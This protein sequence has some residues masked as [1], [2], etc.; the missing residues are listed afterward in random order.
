MSERREAGTPE[1]LQ[2]LLSRLQSLPGIGR[3]SAERIAFWVLKSSHEEAAAL[4]NAITDVKRAVHHCRICWNL[5]ESD[6]CR[7]CANDQRDASII[8]VVEQPR[9]LLS[10]E[11]A[12]MYRGTYHVLMGR[13]D[14][15][16]GVGPD[17]LT[18][19]DLLRRVADAAQNARGAAVAEVILGLNPDLEGDTT[20]LWLEQ[21]LRPS[22][23]RVTRLA[24]GLPS[25]SQIE[26]ANAA[27]LADAL[28]GRRASGDAVA[29]GAAG[30]GARV[31]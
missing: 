15:L 18:A 8:L 27:V 4:A 25:G 3:R 30:G 5:A 20:A 12:G 13:L 22:G 31:P 16:D 11:A 9:D 26:Y 19:R 6:P 21:Q 1:S 29:Q 7:I 23:V 10:I 28:A 17:S 2:R 24:R 14:P